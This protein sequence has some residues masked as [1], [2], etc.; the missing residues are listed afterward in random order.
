VTKYIK[1]I[2]Q[3]QH[4]FTVMDI[5]IFKIVTL[6]QLTTQQKLVVKDFL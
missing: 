3:H 1:R 2:M 4:S 5:T 6:L